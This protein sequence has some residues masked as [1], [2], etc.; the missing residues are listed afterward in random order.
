MSDK[1]KLESHNI[2]LRVSRTAIF[3]IGFPR[4]GPPLVLFEDQFPPPP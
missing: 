3:V 2:V 4:E 1:E